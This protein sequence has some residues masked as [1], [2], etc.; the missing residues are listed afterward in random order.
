MALTAQLSQVWKPRIEAYLDKLP[1]F[2]E[3][4]TNSHYNGEV[5]V[6][7]TLNIITF[8]DISLSDYTGADISFDTGSTT[9]ITFTTDRKRSFGFQVLDTDQQ[10]SISKLVDEFSKRAAIALALD[11]DAFLAT[12]HS[13]ITSNVYGDDTTPIVVGFDSASNEVLPSVALAKLQQ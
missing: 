4:L 5:G 9:G 6:N 7:R 8:G 1:V 3:A 13:S 2:R 10:G 11:V 12:F